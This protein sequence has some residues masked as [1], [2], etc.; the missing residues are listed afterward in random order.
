MNKI[1]NASSFNHSLSWL[2]V[3]RGRSFAAVAPLDDIAAYHVHAGLLLAA[4]HA[5]HVLIDAGG[6][7]GDVG[8]VAAAEARLLAALVAR[9][10]IEAVVHAEGARALRAAEELVGRQRPETLLQWVY[11]QR[12]LRRLWHCKKKRRW[13]VM[14]VGMMGQLVL[15]F[16]FLFF[17]KGQRRLEI[18][19]S[20]I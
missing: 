10:T 16:F 4:V 15:F 9:V 11:L 20:D 18:R 3:L 12:V 17:V 14:L 19:Q 5:P 13:G 8:T 2:R 1:K 7:L 6:V